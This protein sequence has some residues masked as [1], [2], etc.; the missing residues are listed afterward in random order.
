[1]A[2]QQVVPISS[3]GQGGMYPRC[4]HEHAVVSELRRL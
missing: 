3:S 2:I 4:G 1:M